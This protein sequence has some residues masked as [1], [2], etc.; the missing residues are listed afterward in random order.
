MLFEKPHWNWQTEEVVLQIL[1]NSYLAYLG[2]H[3]AIDEASMTACYIIAET[4]QVK[5]SPTNRRLHISV[6]R[7]G[8]VTYVF[9][10]LG[11]GDQLRANAKAHF[12]GNEQTYS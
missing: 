5:S 11:A 8:W 2:N 1:G 10:S 3:S 7:F 9:F 6:I 12:H 4:Q